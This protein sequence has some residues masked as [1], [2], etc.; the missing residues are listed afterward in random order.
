M[1]MAH[2]AF[3]TFVDVD[4]SMQEEGKTQGDCNIFDDK[5]LASKGARIISSD[6]VLFPVNLESYVLVLML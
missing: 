3:T 2:L 6:T 4:M 5:G 1:L